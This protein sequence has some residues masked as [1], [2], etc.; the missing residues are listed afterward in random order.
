[1]NIKKSKTSDRVHLSLVLIWCLFSV[2]LMM[3]TPLFLFDQGKTQ[4]IETEYQI[5][6]KMY[7]DYCDEEGN[8]VLDPAKCFAR[9]E[10]EVDSQSGFYVERHYDEKAE[11]IECFPGC[12]MIRRTINAADEEIRT[13][14][15][16]REGL[17]ATD[18]F[19]CAY[20]ERTYLEGH[21]YEEYYYSKAE[22]LIKGNYGQ[23]GIRWISYDEEGNNTE[24]GYLDE[25]GNIVVSDLGYARARMDYSKK[26]TLTIRYLDVEGNP[27]ALNRGQYGLKYIGSKTIYLNEKGNA[28]FIPEEFLLR[29]AWLIVL[30][31]VGACIVLTLCPKKLRI[32]LV[33]LYTLGILFFTLLSR[34]KMEGRIVVPLFASY[35]GFWSVLRT[36]IQIL[37]NIW[38]FIP[39]GAG[40]LLLFNGKKIPL[41]CI[42]LLPVLIECLQYVKQIGYFEFDDIVHNCMGI[43]IGGYLEEVIVMILKAMGIKKRES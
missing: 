42:F 40:C 39:L 33:L 12:W 24:F 26:G 3:D 8:L 11:W 21:P 22:Q 15:L 7:L 34:N 36:R 28:I 29:H 14:Y 41:L 19:G 6:T 43:I 9:M 13:E 35:R 16:D 5:G 2:L 38:L 30:I 27:V 4:I 31:G 18:E 17:R 20:I 32:V 37:S 25:K 10:T 23:Y 1:M